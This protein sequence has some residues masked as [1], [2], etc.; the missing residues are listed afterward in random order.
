MA[1]RAQVI[2]ATMR[3]VFFLES[4][5]HTQAH[6]KTALP[7]SASA[8]NMVSPVLEVAATTRS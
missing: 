1:P 6:K 8:G 4:K 3:P 2:G 5:V 7:F